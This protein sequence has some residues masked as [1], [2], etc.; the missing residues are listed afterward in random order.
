MLKETTLKTPLALIV[1]LSVAIHATAQEK[2]LLYNDV[3]RKY[4][5]YT[6]AAYD[7]GPHRRFPVVV[8]YHGGGMTMREHMLY[9]QMN[10]TAEREH[11]IVVYPQGIAQDWNVGFGMDYQAGSD[12]VGFTEAMLGQLRQQFRVDPQ[13]VYATGLSRGGFFS[14]RLA[15]EL[16]HL[17]AAVASV[18]APMPEPVVAHHVGKARVGVMIMHGTAD[19]IA[20]YDGKPGGYLS[21]PATYAYWRKHNGLA[22]AAMVERTIER[23]GDARSDVVH[24][25]QGAG[26]IS[27][28]LVTVKEGGH[29]W[30]GA[31]GFNIGL[32][33]GLTNGDIDANATI[34]EFF[35]K[36]HK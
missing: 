10:R 24:A 35:R 34:W 13:R 31:D 3:K 30:P 17:F 26:G 7:S 19:S 29:T 5:V 1:L 22:G 4:I 23:D 28:A 21:A 20:A 12:D 33:L 2:S 9:T 27:V 36:H 15:A 25:E 16:P 14:L 32:P 8:N 11:F 18:G 6:P